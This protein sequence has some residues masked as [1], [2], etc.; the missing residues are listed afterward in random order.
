MATRGNKL[1]DID[2]TLKD[3]S[4]DTGIT[5]KTLRK[6]IKSICEENGIHSY[7]IRNNETGDYIL[8]YEWYE[9]LKLLIEFDKENPFSRANSSKNRN[10]EDIKKYYDEIFSRIEGLPKYIKEEINDNNYYKDNKN[11][12]GAMEKISSK[13]SEL[14]SA[15]FIIASDEQVSFMNYISRI[16]DGWIEN[17][18]VNRTALRL[19]IKDYM[20]NSDS[21][22]NGELKFYS[23]NDLLNEV[24]V[25]LIDEYNFETVSSNIDIYK[26]LI[27]TFKTTE[28][29][30]FIYNG[31]LEGEYDEDESRED[32]NRIA[33]DIKKRIADKDL[34]TMKEEMKKTISNRIEG[35]NSV[36][37]SLQKVSTVEELVEC[38]K[39]EF[40]LN[41]EEEINKFRGDITSNIY[42]YKDDVDRFIATILINNYIK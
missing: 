38:T 1:R 14:I 25:I 23:I 8:L 42:K 16:I 12:V 40:M 21:D 19:A 7:K 36:L 41:E 20:N 17:L 18:Y 11:F 28:D 33:I 22:I 2:Y 29:K 9:L 5:E 26:E 10:I 6:K 35:L 30:R 39:L 3:L 34:F 15:M 4:T 32:I 31:I 37:E 27:D 13:L 24:L